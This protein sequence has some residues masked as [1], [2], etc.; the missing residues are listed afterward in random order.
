MSKKAFVFLADGFEEVE[1]LTPVDY[2]RRADIETITVSI[3]GK[4]AVHGSHK[5]TV[6]AD[7]ILEQIDRKEFQA[8]DVFVLPGGMK[9]AQNLSQ[10][11]ILD[12][13][14]KEANLSGKLIAAICASP[15]VVLDA[16]GILDGKIFTCY[17]EMEKS[18]KKASY[19]LKRVVADGNLIT[20][21]AAGTSAEFAIA[22]VEKLSGKEVADKISQAVLLK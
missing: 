7:R 13:V 1:A 14:L 11:G 8:A 10:N 4:E 22:I 9:G 5:I 17:P 18:V 20:A 12:D 3:N 15:A 2:L 6:L 19:S 21:R 16:K